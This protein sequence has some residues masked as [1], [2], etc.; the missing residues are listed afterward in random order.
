MKLPST[1]FTLGLKDFIKGAI[2][3]V[4][5]PVLVTVQQSLDNPEK[6]LNWKVIGM[7]AVGTFIGYL[8]KNFLSNDVPAAQATILKAEQKAVAQSK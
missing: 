3:A 7:T 6:V 4:I 5:V 2:L 1:A 8:I